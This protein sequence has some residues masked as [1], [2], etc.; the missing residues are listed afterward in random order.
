MPPGRWSKKFNESNAACNLVLIEDQRM[1]SI[2]NDPLRV[3]G[4]LRTVGT[5]GN[6][7][8]EAD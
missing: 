1:R 2:Q 7:N 6:L 3:I 5:S 4:G 8:R